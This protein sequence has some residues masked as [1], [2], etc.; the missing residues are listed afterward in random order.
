MSSTARCAVPAWFDELMA[1]IG[2]DLHRAEDASRRVDNEREDLTA[3]LRDARQRRLDVERLLDPHRPELEAAHLEVEAA[4]QRVWSNNAQFARSTGLKRRRVRHDVADAKDALTA[5]R[6][7]QQQVESA[8]RP[9]RET[10]GA[11]DREVR[12]LTR[13][14]SDLDVERRVALGYVDIEE[15]RDLR[16]ALHQWRRW[17]NGHSVSVD[18]VVRVIEALG[19]QR[20]ID[21]ADVDALALPLAAWGERQGID[22]GSRST[23]VAPSVGPNSTSVCNPWR[24]LARLGSMA[25]RSARVVVERRTTVQPQVLP[26]CC[27]KSEWT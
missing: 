1:T 25:Q 16:D 21:S 18:T 17:A 11:V 27:P 24:V 13:R 2:D 12:D 15:L 6:V 23:R 20:T 22:T 26:Y 5:A 14:L 7:R 4:Q 8:A 10:I 19:D 3:Q 9:A